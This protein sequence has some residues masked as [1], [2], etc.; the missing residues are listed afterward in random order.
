[1]TY[2]IITGF[3]EAKGTNSGYFKGVCVKIDAGDYEISIAYDNS[4]GSME[5]LHRADMKIFNRKDDVDVTKEIMGKDGVYH[6]Q[7]YEIKNAIEIC[8]NKSFSKRASEL[9]TKYENSISATMEVLDDIKK[10]DPDV[11]KIER[12]E[13]V[14]EGL[15]E[16]LKD[17]KSLTELNH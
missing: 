9:R 15:K 5:H 16:N 17:I 7:A 10:N 14:I 13:N 4:A 8:L 11:E 1:M 12:T 2:A 3:R 6:V